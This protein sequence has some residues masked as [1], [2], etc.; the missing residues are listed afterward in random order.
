MIKLL[1]KKY[2][3]IGTLYIIYITIILLAYILLLIILSSIG[4]TRITSYINVVKKYFIYTIFSIIK[5]EII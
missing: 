3:Y 2:K 5:Y 1:L 4:S